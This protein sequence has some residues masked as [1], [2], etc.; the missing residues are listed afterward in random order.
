MCHLEREFKELKS[1]IKSMKRK[2]NSPQV[3]SDSIQ[4]QISSNTCKGAN[5]ETTSEESQETKV[6]KLLN[7][8]R[9][10]SANVDKEVTECVRRISM[11]VF[12]R[13]DLVTCS[14]TGKKT[15]HS[16]D[17]PKPALDGQKMAVVEQAV[18]LKC[19][20]LAKESFRKKFDNLLKMERRVQQCSQL[21]KDKVSKK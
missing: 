12:T 6:E 21:L 18:L 4:S 8:I 2:L 9:H 3:S 19:P 10:L 1:T 20:S 11:S 17:V 13:N 5:T 7:S 16:G 15:I 14:R